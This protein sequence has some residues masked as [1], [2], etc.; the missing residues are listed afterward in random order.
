MER[1]RERILGVRQSDQAVAMERRQRVLVTVAL[2]TGCLGMGIAGSIYSFN[3]YIN[4][5]K[6]TFGYTQSDMEIMAAMGNFGISL[7]FPAGFLCERLGGRVTS[8][9]AMLLAGGAFFLAYS[10]TFSTAFYSHDH[11][12]LLQDLYFF[13]AGFGAI[14]TYMAAMM[15]TVLNFSLAHRGKIIGILDACFSGGP[16]L[17]ALVYGEFFVRGHVNDEQHQDLRGFYLMS[18]VAFIAINLLGMA[19]LGV[20][21]DPDAITLTTHGSKTRLVE[22]DEQRGDEEEDKE[23]DKHRDLKDQGEVKGRDLVDINPD[24]GGEDVTGL[25][26]ARDFDFH[27]LLWSY[28]FCASLQLTFQAN[29]TTFLKSTHLEQ[30]NTLLT[31]LTFA[32]G[33][34]SKFAIGLLSDL[35]VHRVPRVVLI[36]VTTVVQTA[37]LTLCVFKGDTF[38]VLLIGTLGVGIPNGATWCLTPVMTSEFF[39]TRYFGRNWGFMMLGVAFMGLG[40]QKMFGALYDSEIQVTGSTD[41]YGLKCFRWTFVVLTGLSFCSCIFYVGLLE[42][43]LR[44]RRWRKEMRAREKHVQ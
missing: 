36:L 44:V 32:S 2:V 4:A 40:L 38:P 9:A 42:R 12:V 19:F 29:I 27:F 15:T 14:F 24:A 13:L 6:K 43:R 21:R 7:G 1:E 16:A 22:Q 41:C 26:L 39:G 37:V 28:I 25:R 23:G 18:A 35:L 5:I 17:V 20:Y 8:L 30:Y 10:T 11:M 31:T 3:S 33:T 34:V